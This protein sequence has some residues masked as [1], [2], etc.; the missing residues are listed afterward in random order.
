MNLGEIFNERITELSEAD[1]ISDALE[2]WLLVKRDTQKI[3]KIWRSQPNGEGY[4]I[5]S[6]P[7]VYPY[8]IVNKK[9]GNHAIIGSECI[10]KIGNQHMVK[11]RNIQK[12][13]E[14]KAVHRCKLCLKKMSSDKPFHKTCYYKAKICCCCVKHIDYND[15]MIWETKP[16]CSKCFHYEQHTKNLKYIIKDRNCKYCVNKLNNILDEQFTLYC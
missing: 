8:H 4:C 5:C 2:E 16:Y 12:A 14:N 6:N 13:D 1:N 9:N 3:K 15:L 11:I 7:I 10:N